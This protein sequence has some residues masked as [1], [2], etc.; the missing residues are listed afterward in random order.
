MLRMFIFAIIAGIVFAIM[1]SIGVFFSV[2]SKIFF[3]IA[4]LVFLVYLFKL[5]FKIKKR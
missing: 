2:L 3:V 4:G 1:S 5:L